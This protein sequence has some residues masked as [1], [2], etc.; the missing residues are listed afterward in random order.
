MATKIVDATE[1]AVPLSSHE[2]QITWPSHVELIEK[3]I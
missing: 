3:R 2:I 1:Q